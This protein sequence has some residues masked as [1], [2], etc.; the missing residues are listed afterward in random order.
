MKPL[1]VTCSSN[2]QATMHQCGVAAQ[3][4]GGAVSHDGA[5]DQH[6]AAIDD[7]EDG[8]D[9]FVDDDRRDTGFSDGGD[10]APNLVADGGRGLR[11]LRRG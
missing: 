5:F 10:D 4:F 9:G 8:G 3:G 11:S 6:R 1:T 2:A 7:G